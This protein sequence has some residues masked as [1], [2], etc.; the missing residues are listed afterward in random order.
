MEEMKKEDE[1]EHVEEEDEEEYDGEDK[2]VG[3]HDLVANKV[4]SSLQT[5][6]AVHAKLVSAAKLLPS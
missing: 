2:E 1:E 3:H 6:L 5:F 4:F